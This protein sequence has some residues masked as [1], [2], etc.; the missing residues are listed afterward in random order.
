MLNKYGDF[1]ERGDEFIINTP[2]IERNWYNYFFTDNYITFT[3][4]TGAG[5]GFLQDSLGNRLKVVRE[6][7]TY[8]VC[9]GEGWS[10]CGLPVYDKPDFYECRHGIGYTVIT[11]ERN[12]IRTE[13]GLFV[14]NEDDET[15]GYEVTFVIVKNNTGEK[16]DVKI[17]SYCENDFDGRYTYQG[18]NVSSLKYSEEINGMSYRVDA[19]EWSGEYRTFEAFMTCGQK[20]SGYDCARNAFI[21]PYGSSADPAALHKG[22]CTGSECIAEKNCYALE[23]TLSLLPGEESFC[24]FIT[25]V[26]DKKEIINGITE[27]FSTE[28]K[29]EKELSDVKN[30]YS[31]IIGKLK[32]N[33]PDRELNKLFNYWLKYQT[34]LGSRWARVRHN[35]F[36]DMT[37]D[38]ECLGVINPSLAWERLKRIM[39][40][41]YSNGYAPRTFEDGAIRDNN[42]SDNTVWLNYTAYYILNELGDYEKHLN[43]KVKFND[44]S[45]ATVYEH[46]RLS[47]D[48]LYNFRGLHGLIKIWCGDWNDCL[49]RVGKNGKGVSVWLSMAFCRAAKMFAELAKTAG[50]TEDAETALA[51]AEEISKLI[52]VYGFDKEGGYYIY[53]INDEGRKIGGSE[54][55][56]GRIHLAPQIFAVLSGISKDGKDKTAMEIADKELTYELGTAVMTPP[57]THYD[58]GVGAIGIKHPGVH[59]NGGVYLHAMCWKLAADAMLGDEDKVAF[60]IEHILPFR[61]PVVAGR[62]E[63]YVLPNSY[64]GKET[65]Y[66][67][68]TPGQSWRTA[69]GQWFLKSLVN[70]VFGFMPTPEGLRLQPCLPK[71]WKEAEIIKEYRGTEYHIK[72]L[73]T[74][75]K[76]I[77]A[78][79]EEITGGTLPVPGG[80]LEVICEV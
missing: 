3:S 62:C 8:A 26:T 66:R 10:L 39:T 49:N 21:G 52:D 57:Y 1:N 2:D 75:R 59:E 20:V 71:S 44:G 76:K 79:G 60:D 61:N 63:P 78:G 50:K 64:M 58:P 35:G 33:T 69:S 27:R 36:R 72:Y 80:I 5:E 18:Y 65:G 48:W 32:I 73:R 25:G 56:E 15:T 29:T 16:K 77:T 31:G 9:D 13:Y 74:G 54:E 4:Q 19:G 70:Y 34:N 40:Y 37:S 6:R 67:Y 43:E 28:E 12:G 17:I 53:A 23:T 68:G 30:K 41:Q 7:G 46:L 11:E 14:P 22:G 55:K 42:F 51:Q 45:E 47:V 24:S 38:T